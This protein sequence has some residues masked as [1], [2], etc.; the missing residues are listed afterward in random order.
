MKIKREERLK[1]KIG[2]WRKCEKIDVKKR[3]SGKTERKI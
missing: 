1:N 2:K 3:S